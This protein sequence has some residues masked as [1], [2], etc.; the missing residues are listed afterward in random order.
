MCSFMKGARRKMPTTRPLAPSWDLPMV[1]DALPSPPFEPLEQAEL[2]TLS[3]NTAFLLVLALAK[4]IGEI[5]A[6][7]V[8]QAC[9]KFA[10]GNAKVSMQPN[11]AFRSA[12]AQALTYSESSSCAADLSGQDSGF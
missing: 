1:L 7:S 11:P 2:K 5:H 8:N 10:P 4:H 12:G 3:L 9:M 6:L